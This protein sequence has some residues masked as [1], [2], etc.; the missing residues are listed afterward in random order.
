MFILVPPSEGKSAVSGG[1]PFAVACPEWA[2]D[3]AMVQKLL[4]TL[5]AAQRL[6]WYGVKDAAKA[7][8]W[9][10]AHLA[11]LETPGLPAIERYTGVV[12]QHFGYA[13]LRKKAAARTRLL[14]VSALFGLIPAGA[15]IP[16]YKLPMNPTIARFWKPINSAR[17]QALAQ[18]KPVLNLLSQSYAK[19]V[20][21][22]PLLSPD[23]R[24]AAGTKAAGH[25]GKAIKGRFLRFLIEEDVQHEGAF[26]RFQEEGFLWN[27]QDFVRK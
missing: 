10:E 18:G 6:K 2:G 27:G 17:L 9:H 15:P 11:A 26:D 7:K 22:A 23:F 4:R 16:A 13:A 24:V 3:T 5:P 20:A 21:Y 19:G 1:V 14:F 25:A 12:Y 8:A